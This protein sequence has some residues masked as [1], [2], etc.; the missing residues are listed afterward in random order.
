M[1]RAA[2]V[3]VL[4][5]GLAPAPAHARLAD[6]PR[7]AAPQGTG[8]L[9]VCVLS[10]TPAYW[11]LLFS[12]SV[13]GG[14][15]VSAQA[16]PVLDDPST[17]S[18]LPVGT[19]AA[20]TRVTLQEQVPAG[21][22][23]AWI[24]TDPPDSLLDFDRDAGTALVD[25]GGGATRVLFDDEP[26][27]PAQRGYVEV[28]ADRASVDGRPDPEVRGPFTYTAAAADGAGFSVAVDAGQCS[29]AFAVQA[30][31]VHV[32]QAAVATHSVADIFTAPA[33]RLAARN[34]ARGT[35]DAAV[36]VSASANDATQL[37]FVVRRDRAQLMLCATASDPLDGTSF[38]FDV[39]DLDGVATPPLTAQIV[40][41]A[42]TVQCQVAASYPVGDRVDVEERDPGPDVT[43]SGGGVAT[44][45]PG[46]DTVRLVNTAWGRL[47]VCAA[48]VDGLITPP[49]LR[50]R[51]DGGAPLA[52]R[53][54]TCSLPAR[55]A[56]S[57]HT[58]VQMPDPLLELVDGGITAAPPER[59]VSVV[60]PALR[61]TLAVP[62]GSESSALFADRI[63]RATVQ[64]CAEVAPGSEDA[65]GRRLF[66][67][68]VAP[69]TGP[70]FTAAVRAGTCSAPS[71]PFAVLASDGS[72]AVVTVDAPTGP[73][74]V[75]SITL[76]G[77]RDLR[78]TCGA[79]T[80]A[81]TAL[82]GLVPGAAVL[83][84]TARAGR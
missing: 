84:F 27:L 26:V 33:G 50:F 42:R 49:V 54:G 79:G 1:K 30:G 81:R 76:A 47:S 74:A 61:M 40:A 78:V 6:L 62:F 3:A 10:E 43:V 20:G 83:T 64:V 73:Y 21:A 19:F 34:L 75:Q 68:G 82:F 69:A 23:I 28:C 31:R 48:P 36:P 9:A 46:I 37:H 22:H 63:R 17:W 80:C 32:A 67:F 41:R 70:P 2:M 66:L 77:G 12:F 52:V 59:V 5:A 56:V 55:V 35:A 4:A 57:N 24:D 44:I 14:P 25:V 13:E 38:A 39:T 18:C 11:G 29:D 53:G 71:G 51:I 58:V 15:L 7:A 65:L 45:A 60:A 8:T 16:G 72:P